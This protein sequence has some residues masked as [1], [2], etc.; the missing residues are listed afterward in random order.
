MPRQPN[1]AEIPFEDDPIL[2]DPPSPEAASDEDPSDPQSESDNPESTPEPPEAA[3][4]PYQTNPVVTASGVHCPNPDCRRL[5]RKGEII[6]STLDP[7][8]P[9]QVGDITYPGRRIQRCECRRAA[10]GCG[11][12]YIVAVPWEPEPEPP[13]QVECRICGKTV[14]ETD[15]ELEPRPGLAV[16]LPCARK[17]AAQPWIALVKAING[18]T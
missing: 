16:C 3:T 13:A 11:R 6:Q 12:K 4:R 10:G 8:M 9:L 17:K 15:I 14:P 18:S 7:N 1:P 5:R 2:A